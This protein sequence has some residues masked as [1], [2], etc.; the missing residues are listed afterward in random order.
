VHTP[1]YLPPGQAHIEFTVSAIRRTPDCSACLRVRF[2]PV[3]QDEH[4]NLQPIAQGISQ[5][6]SGIWNV[7]QLNRTSSPQQISVPLPTHECVG[8]VGYVRFE[9]SVSGNG[10]AQLDM[11]DAYI[12]TNLIEAGQDLAW[13]TP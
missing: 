4:G 3:E 10:A 1:F 8:Q 7:A 5:Q 11:D 13:T 12:P 2:V 9:L 6:P